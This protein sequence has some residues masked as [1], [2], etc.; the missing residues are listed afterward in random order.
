MC[1]LSQEV[2]RWKLNLFGPVAHVRRNSLVSQN[3]RDMWHLSPDITLPPSGKGCIAP[4][5][6]GD[7][8]T[9]HISISVIHVQGEFCAAS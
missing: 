8:N 1:R 5:L 6:A 9:Y 7:E 2:E 3:Q 4:S